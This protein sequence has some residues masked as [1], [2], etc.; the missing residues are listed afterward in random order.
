MTV[1][2]DGTEQSMVIPIQKKMRMTHAHAIELTQPDP[3]ES[4]QGSTLTRGFLAVT[5]PWSAPEAIVGISR[6][7]KKLTVYV[8]KEVYP[9]LQSLAA[10]AEKRPERLT[11]LDVVDRK[12][13]QQKPPG[14]SPAPG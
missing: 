13:D 7:K 14:Q 10:D 11:T 4:P 1:T 6:H 3:A 12:P 2:L 9:D 5:R 8:D